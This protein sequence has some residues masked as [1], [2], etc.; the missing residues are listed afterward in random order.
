MKIDFYLKLRNL[1][2]SL[3]YSFIMN[4]VKPIR[5]KP[6]NKQNKKLRMQ[7]IMQPIRALQQNRNLFE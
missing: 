6:H 3:P 5:P 7:I 4:F 2:E 1:Q